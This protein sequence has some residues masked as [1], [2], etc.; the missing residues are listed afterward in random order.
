MGVYQQVIDAIKQGDRFLVAS[1]AHP[2]GDGIGSTIALAKG[3]ESLGKKV[4]M[5]NA[6]PVPYNLK[7]LPY[8]GEVVSELGPDEKFDVTFM[9]DCSQR[10]RIGGDAA[11][12][13]RERL[14]K[15]ILI[16]HHKLNSS[17]CDIV[18]I[19]VDAAATGEVIFRL[20]K[21]M[22]LEVTKEIANLIFCTFVVDSGS[23]RYSN[24]SAS[25]LKDAS[26]LVEAGASPWAISMAM[27]ESNS[28]CAIDLLR[29]VLGTFEMRD[30]TAWVVLTQQMFS[31][32]C[33]SEDVA[34]EFI[35]YPRSILG[36]EVAMLFRQLK[37]EEPASS[38]SAKGGSKEKWK[39]SF[40]SKNAVDVQKIA[41]AFNGGGHAHAAG[42]TLEG[43]LASVKERVFN[44]VRKCLSA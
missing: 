2:D 27:D 29:M 33:A 11:E 17:E 42:C 10:D 36:V 38:K 30:K 18:C 25:L 28:P 22:G 16:D 9:V 20:F 43:D 35:N 13:D 14:G 40:R 37:P 5:Y 31:D 4:K 6:D 41:S 23:F 1:H 34:E 15:L 3:L 21:A 12:I 26:E 8:S 32:S 19:D 7:F 24:T 44:E 39:A